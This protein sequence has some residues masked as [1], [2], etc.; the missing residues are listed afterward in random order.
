MILR[1]GKIIK[2]KIIRFSNNI[3]IQYY[4]LQLFEKIEKKTHYDNI[5]LNNKYLL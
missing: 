1:N 4:I 3:Q 5:L 2:S